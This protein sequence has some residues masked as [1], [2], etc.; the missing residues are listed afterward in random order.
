MYTILVNP[1]N[2]LYGSQKSRVMQRSKLVD[3]LRFIVEPTYNDI[4]MTTATV[5]LEYV[6]PVSRKYKAVLL[7]L[8]DE[9]YN[10]CYL[11]YKLPFDTDLTSEA[12]SLELQLT[13]AYVEMNYNGVGIQRVRKTS[14][15]TIEIIPIT[16]WSD[17]VPD[18][19]LLSLDD[20]LIKID[21]Q[22]RAMNDYLDVIDS[23]KVDN[24]VYDNANETLQLSSKGVGIGNK[25][26]VRDMLDDG[27]P[28]VDLDSDSG[29]SDGSDSENNNGCNCGCD[30]EENVVE[31]DDIRKPDEPNKNC[32]NVVKF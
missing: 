13:F 17:I 18:D 32:Y 31:F 19:A 24:L 1:D 2:T 5:M 20:R 9:R 28:V 15:T 27:T 25:V 23:N 21:A 26:S 7:V 30:C 22:M 14:S 29:T 11:Q 10:G 16:A 4:D 3:N 8:D 6:L 12:G